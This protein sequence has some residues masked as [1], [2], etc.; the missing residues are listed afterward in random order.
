MKNIGSTILKMGLV[1]CLLALP[2]ASFANSFAGNLGGPAPGYD[3]TNGNLVGNDFAG[4]NLGEA[5]TF[6]AGSTAQLNS[7][8][9]ALSCYLSGYCSDDLTI[10]LTSDSS[11]MPGSALETFTYSSGSLGDFGD[12]NPLVVL[13]SVT[14]PLLTAG[15]HY[16]ITITDDGNDT[17]VWNLN[18]TGDSSA[19][20]TSLDGGAT[21]ANAGL[22]PG[23][24]QVNVPEPA[25]LSLLGSALFLGIAR[26]AIRRKK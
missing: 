8:S 11:G 22:T 1:L 18:Q 17:A 6:T 15:T 23:A 5:I 26:K 4:D 3:T 13:D 10:A 7:I 14:N 12:P 21:W 25:S 20:L 24:Y 19:T 2:G 16:W 9:L